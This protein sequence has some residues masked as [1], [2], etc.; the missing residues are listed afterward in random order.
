[1]ISLKN[2]F[3]LFQFFNL[4]R[5]FFSIIVQFVKWNRSALQILTNLTR[6]VEKIEHGVTCRSTGTTPGALPVLLNFFVCAKKIFR[7][8][9]LFVQSFSEFFNHYCFR[10]SQKFSLKI[11][12]NSSPCLPNTFANTKTDFFPQTIKKNS[13]NLP[14][15]YCI[16]SSPEDYT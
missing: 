1:M 12:R 4:V 2:W 13:F 6:I 7:L 9:R 15:F 11:S 10:I 14:R 8:F 5:K 16:V 3:F